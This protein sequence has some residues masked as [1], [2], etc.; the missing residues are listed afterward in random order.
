[1]HWDPQIHRHGWQHSLWL[2]V[3][4]GK[5][6][7]LL[8]FICSPNWA[9]GTLLRHRMETLLSFQHLI[10]PSM[11]LPVSP[12]PWQLFSSARSWLKSSWW[13]IQLSCKYHPHE[14]KAEVFRTNTSFTKR[15][16]KTL[17]S[18]LIGYIQSLLVGGTLGSST[19]GKTN[20]S[21]HSHPEV[22]WNYQGCVGKS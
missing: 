11:N 7:E 2:L 9:S 8:T 20:H 10:E 6:R 1:M 5:K 18:K 17:R 19:G 21:S 14:H 12:C 16:I 13:A 3:I 22:K 4:L 15:G